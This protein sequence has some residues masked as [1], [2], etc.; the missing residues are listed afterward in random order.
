MEFKSGWL[1]KELL[2]PVRNRKANMTVLIE[3]KMKELDTKGLGYNITMVLN[4]VENEQ[5]AWQGCFHN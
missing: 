4:Y 5:R 1:N 2:K 3:T